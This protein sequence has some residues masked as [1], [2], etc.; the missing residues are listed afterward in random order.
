MPNQPCPVHISCVCA[1]GSPVMN[2]SSE[3][4]DSPVFLAVDYGFVPIAIGAPGMIPQLAYC[5]SAVSLLAAQ[6]CATK[7]AVIATLDPPAPTNPDPTGKPPVK[8]KNNPP[9]PPP[10]NP[11][12]GGPYSIFTNTPQTGVYVCPDGN[13]FTYLVPAG[14]FAAKSQLAANI[15]AQSFARLQ[16]GLMFLC[17]SDLPQPVCA[18]QPYSEQITVSGPQVA[19]FDGALAWTVTAGTV[20]AGMNLTVSSG[21]TATLSGTPTT[22]GLYVFFVS[23]TDPLGNTMEKGYMFNVAGIT[24]ATTLPNG[25]AGQSY[26]AQLET[27][28]FINA[29]TFSTPDPADLPDGVTLSAGGLLSGTPTIAEEFTFTATATDS[30]SGLACSGV[31]NVNVK[32]AL[33]CPAKTG[34]LVTS[35]NDFY[36]IAASTTSRMVFGGGAPNPNVVIVVNTATNG[37][38]SNLSFT[39]GS[40]ARNGCYAPTVDKFY[41]ADGPNVSLDSIQGSTGAAVNMIPSG[42][43]GFGGNGFGD[44][45]YRPVDDRVY[46]VQVLSNGDAGIAQINPHSDTVISGGDLGVF[47]TGAANTLMLIY[48]PAPHECLIT[49]AITNPN[50]LTKLSVPGFAVLGTL[51]LTATPMEPYSPVFCPLTGHLYVASGGSVLEIDPVTMTVVFTFDVSQGG[52]YSA[53]GGRDVRQS[54]GAMLQQTD[55]DNMHGT[56]VTINTAARTIVCQQIVEAGQGGGGVLVDQTSGSGH[57]YYTITHFDGTPQ[58]HNDIFK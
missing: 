1:D 36:P 52:T 5:T 53:T 17:L 4:P 32:A 35:G 57:I 13:D 42:S 31:F 48:V 38:L 56:L 3:A 14:V 58:N 11:G 27:A 8:P 47:S 33:T 25:V 22:P 37:I 28:G 41:V 15:E 12:A 21:T 39:P 46:A 49:N 34:S 9:A 45:V 43:G 50:V 54:D 55:F 51:D 16:A 26:S 24:N 10:N 18:G 19:S 20:P 40:I 30:V 6:L 44:A 7:M 2:L 29:V 23:V